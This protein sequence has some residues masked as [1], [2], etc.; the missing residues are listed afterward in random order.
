M[1]QKFVAEIQT[2]GEWSFVFFDKKFSHAV[3]KR[4]KAGD[5]R[6]QNYFGGTVETDLQPPP[7]LI[8][9]AKTIVENVSED[10]LYARVDGVEIDGELC[11][12]ELEL[13]EPALFL[14]NNK[15]AAQRFASAIADVFE[16][17]KIKTT[18]SAK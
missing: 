15:F 1:I 3:L 16:S 11:S 13:I 8:D 17:H 4:A 7:D 5:F 10:L 14:E 12:M 2:K 18:V 6:V 9:Q